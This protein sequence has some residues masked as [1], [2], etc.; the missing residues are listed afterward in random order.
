[1][2]N[3]NNLTG[4]SGFES[5]REALHYLGGE[6]SCGE[7]CDARRFFSKSQ[8]IQNAPLPKGMHEKLKYVSRRLPYRLV[9]VVDQFTGRQAWMFINHFEGALGVGHYMTPPMLVDMPQCHIPDSSNLVAAGKF[10]LFY[11][12]D[13]PWSSRL[14]FAKYK[15]I[16]SELLTGDYDLAELA[17]EFGD[18]IHGLFLRSLKKNE[19]WPR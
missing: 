1:M 18:P 6:M 17:E 2:Y 7:L 3:R 10:S 11:M 19:D 8:R 5:L 4:M 16:I 12:W 13:A 15:L 14:N 9:H